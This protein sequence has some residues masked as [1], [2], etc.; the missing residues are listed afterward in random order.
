MNSDIAAGKWKQL[1]ADMRSA[2]ADLTDDDID[3]IGGK[4]DKFI[5]VMQE[6]YGK[7]KEQAEKA[8]DDF[9]AKFD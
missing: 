7:T 4:K 9:K 5:G 2:W 3:H 6:K 1:K 8:F